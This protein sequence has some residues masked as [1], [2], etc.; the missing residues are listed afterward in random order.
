MKIIK[1]TVPPFYENTYV[2]LHNH[3]AWVIDPG[4]DGE[5]L[6]DVLKGNRIERFEVLLTH[7]HIDHI[8]G[9]D[10]LIKVW[11]DIK[12]H[13][14][15]KDEKLY[16]NVKIQAQMFHQAEPALPKEILYVEDGELLNQNGLELQVMHT[17]GHSPGSV[18]YLLKNEVPPVLFS[19]DTLFFEGIGRSD[20]FGGDHD[21][22]MLSIREKLFKLPEDTRCLP[23]HG[24]ETTIGHEKRFN[25]FLTDIIGG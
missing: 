23:G 14:H 8:S 4:G 10:A 24:Q 9:L 12:V 19:G 7:A 3:F 25:P 17:P 2:V 20:L 5:L 21:M 13:L 1:F 11:P 18:C 16:K 6:V 15:R 22:L